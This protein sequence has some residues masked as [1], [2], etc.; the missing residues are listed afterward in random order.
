MRA[1]SL[2]VVC[3]LAKVL[4]L[5]GRDVPLSAWAPLAYLWQD[6]LVVLVFAAVEY[7]TR[8][9]PWVAGA[10]YAAAVVYVAVN[11]PLACQLS[12]PLTWPLLTATRSAIAD[13]ILHHVTPANVLRVAAVLAA[14]AVMPRLLRPVAARVG[15]RGRLAAVLVA[16]AL[17]PLGPAATARV[18]TN[19][20]HRNALA[21]LV[22][23]AL[24]RVTAVGDDAD[25][26]LSPFGSAR[27]DDLSR[28]RGAAAGRNV[29]VIH[30][31][32]T[33]AGYLR[34]Y[35]AAE[36]PMPR[37]SALARRSI[38]FENTYTVYPETIKTFFSTQ[39]AVYPS[40][41]TRAED[42]EPAHSPAL[43]ELLAAE[44]YRTGLFHSGRFRYLGM[45]A[46]LRH[47][48]YQTQED[49]GDI[50]G[51]RES[52][53]GIDE[54]ST[55]RRMLAWVDA[56]PR[57]RP[58]LLA[59]MP[60]A[61]HHP[62]DYPGAGP[63]PD[64]EEEI[65]RYRNALHYADASVGALLDGLRE[66]G[67]EDDTLFVVCGDHGE[68][69]GQH[70]GN[71]GHVLFLYEENVRVPMLVAAPGLTDEEVR[72]RRP[73][74][75]V[76]LAPTVLDLLGLPSPSAY[77]GRSLLYPDERMALFC[78][79]YSLGLVGLR[80]GR[81][82]LIHELDSGRSQLYDLEEDPQEKRDLAGEHPERVDAYRRHLLRWVAAQK[83]LVTMKWDAE[84]HGF[85]GL[86]RSRLIV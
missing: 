44:G 61:G 77:Q 68:A 49:A 80:D 7:L 69:F 29:V 32:S 31:E 22:T 63:F 42:Y 48:G 17:L 25:W 12:T 64:D 1:A 18:P 23:S 14:A 50:G 11:V 72:V 79:D 39:C 74:S 13:S 35:G 46:V 37:L 20:L 73:A 21:A 28:Y 41:D 8:R 10:L 83:H 51:E 76:D 84:K 66:R 27:S 9:R 70:E 59:Y 30:L 5:I 62:Y 15:P 85:N 19:G 55:V 40:L 81:W 45:E 65:D 6:L 53:F 54:A 3:V 26:A 16:V 24:P 82:K 67:L 52:S 78:T 71:F 86:S 2:F 36:D 58:F 60:I 75:L 4:V 43:A 56:Q 38:L 33:A 57:D 47:R 34:S